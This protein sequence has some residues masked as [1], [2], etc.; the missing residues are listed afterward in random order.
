VLVLR[1]QFVTTTDEPIPKHLAA[2]EPE[3]FGS[4]I[5]VVRDVKKT[6]GNTREFGS[7]WT[8]SLISYILCRKTLQAGLQ[9]T[10]GWKCRVPSIFVC[11]N[12]KILGDFFARLMTRT[13]ADEIWFWVAQRF[14]AAINTIASLGASA[15]E[16][17]LRD[18]SRSCLLSRVLL[19]VLVLSVATSA[20]QT[21]SSLE[22]SRPVRTWEFLP[23]VG[24]RAALFGNESGQ[25]EAWVYPLKIFRNF[26]LIFHV[27]GRALPAETLVRTLIVH[28]ESATLVYAGDN[29]SVRE[30]LFVP[31]HQ[32]GAVVLL[33]IETEQP[34]EIEAAFTGDFQLEW[35][36]AVGGTFHFWDESQNAFVFG[37]EQKKFAAIVGSPSGNSPNLAY[38]TNYSSS[39]EDSLHLG[40]I[41]K[42]RGSKLIV[43]A[44]SIQGLADAQTNY[45][46]L[47]SSYPDLMRDSAQYYRDYLSRTVNLT[48]PDAQLQQA[49]DWS[50]ISMV[51]G[52]VTN[53]TLG[54]GLV[55]GYRTSGISQRPGFAWFFG[56]DSFWTSFALNSIGDF[57]TTRTAIEFISKF[58]RDDG[59]I[60]HEISQG[61]SFVNW[62]KDY[63]YGYASAD[64]TPLYI[65]ATNDYLTRSGDI[66]FARQKWD[67]LWKAYQFM[68][69][70]YD[71]QSFPQNFG[72]GH[73]WIEG[74]P[75]LPVKTEF[76][77][78]G[79]GI[80][81][82]RALAN[83]AKLTGKDGVS[84]D[85]Q[86]AFERQKP[87][88]NQ[89]FWSPEKKAFAYALDQQNRRVEELSV[90]TTVPMW[91]GVTD[92]DKSQSTIQQ[93]A[94]ADH[95]T[96][97]GM[98]II[99]NRSPVYNGSGYHF[100][101]VWPLFTGWA[102]VGEYRY[103]QP[104]AA[105]TNLRSNA[106]LALDGSLG[107][108]TEVLSGDYY[109]P[110][111][112]SSPHQIWSAAMVISPILRGM[113]GLD[114]DAQTHTLTFAPHVPSDWQ[115]F[116]V[117]NLHVGATNL[118]LNYKRTP[119][120]ITVEMKP[121]GSSDCTIDFSPAISLRSS[122]ASV[123]VNGRSIPFHADANA[124]DQHVSMRIPISQAASTVRVRLKNDFGLSVVN[125]LPALGNAS[126]GLRVL[127]GT[128]NASHS[129][130]TLSLSGLSGNTYTLLVWNS[131]QL[132][133]VR[134]GKLESDGP[135]QAKL[136]VQFPS[137][138]PA[139]YLH[140]D[141]VLN[142]VGAK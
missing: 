138:N 102:S 38:Q 81:A 55:A 11:A 15:P 43:I 91:F 25:M 47:A 100:G 77:Q 71:A 109:Q 141:V 32:P 69:S 33:D 53:A 31:V 24:T 123:E 2:K 52:L 7:R 1:L 64:A 60:P 27:D 128:W 92:Q 13:I 94:D 142:F 51:Q 49:Y 131:S 9:R 95:Q 106:L 61:A 6:R 82:L 124:S 70:T 19:G 88:F 35:P 56:R 135:D 127:A 130:L 73:G 110:V 37:E 97:W 103:H 20:Q 74:G 10:L 137:A 133:T 113:L 57:A 23:V 111:S 107:H 59:K 98:R 40:A 12:W 34:L 29:F 78:S 4:M 63:P 5:S 17:S 136:I 3:Q 41:N 84:K 79:L 87:L 14:T 139:S 93:L 112:T 105:Y 44:G 46:R 121:S 101:S 134:G 122:V 126:E 16:G 120:A 48:L 90:L 45:Q 86:A 42:G 18:V 104:L 96:D 75:L 85:L 67:S 72:F 28:P 39:E 99:S 58:Q 118:T 21:P 119:G 36:A 8:V 132:A 108:V 89:T 125:A 50:R 116:S 68:R 76:Y 80:E 62:F 30:T 22:L 26:H 117:D 129:Q 114:V 140:Q 115:S 83:L 54:T 65:I 66:D